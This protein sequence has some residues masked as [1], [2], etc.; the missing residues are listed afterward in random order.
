M[1]NTKNRTETS[2]SEDNPLA[3][4]PDD[5]PWQD[6]ACWFT[7]DQL[8]SIMQSLPVELQRRFKEFW[9]YYAETNTSTSIQEDVEEIVR[10]L[11]PA[12]PSDPTY[13]QAGA[14]SPLKASSEVKDVEIGKVKTPKT[15]VKTSRRVITQ[16]ISE[17]PTTK[18]R[19][20]E[21]Q[22]HIAQIEWGQD[23]C[24]MSEKGADVESPVVSP[25]TEEQ[26]CEKTS[27]S[28]NIIQHSV[29][30]PGAKRLLEE[31]AETKQRETNILTK[32]ARLAA[33]PSE[34][35]K[36][37]M[38]QPEQSTTAQ[39]RIIQKIYKPADCRMALAAGYRLMRMADYHRGKLSEVESF[40]MIAKMFNVGKSRLAGIFHQ[41]KVGTSKL[42]KKHTRSPEHLSSSSSE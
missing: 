42:R 15:K 35:E 30:R 39:L 31:L 10:H 5:Y 6:P 1:S 20:L 17:E 33:S 23:P 18:E 11:D 37:K 19:K 21:I 27:G 4:I 28:L 14:R 34:C 9:Q 26:T 12:M 36:G 41:S 7:H 29:G 22:R 13:Y 38:E 3:Y 40:A 25:T 16:Q 32:L 8:D 24:E 2:T